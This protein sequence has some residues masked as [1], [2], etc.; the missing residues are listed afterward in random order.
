[1]P[2]PGRGCPA[3]PESRWSL[4]ATRIATAFYHYL[5]ATITRILLYRE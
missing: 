3:F 5:D 1:M 2:A 4:R